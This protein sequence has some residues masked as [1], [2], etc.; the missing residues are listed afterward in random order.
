MNREN[1]FR[2]KRKDDEKWEEGYY[3]RHIKRTIYP[4]GDSVKPED[5]QHAIMHD[6]FSDWGMPRDT[7]YY[8]V[9][10]VTLCRSTGLTDRKKKRIW[11]NDILMCHG[12]PDDLVKVEFGEFSVIDPASDA[13]VDR[14]IGWHCEVIKSSEPEQML[15]FYWSGPLT[16]EYIKE[17]EMEVIGNIFDNPELLEERSIGNA[18]NG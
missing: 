1:L 5:L 17:C 6:G 10:P 18:H 9:D 14:V 12:N 3:I 2:A 8:D 16:D 13:I 11:E 4:M 15:P 7:V